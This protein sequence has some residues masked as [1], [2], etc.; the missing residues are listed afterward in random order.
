MQ[1]H[2]TYTHEQML[3]AMQMAQRL[4]LNTYSVKDVTII[5]RDDI[6][7]K[8]LLRVKDKCIAD[9]A[10]I[11]QEIKEKELREIQWK[12][13]SYLV[14]DRERMIFN[15]NNKL[16]EY[17]LRLNTERGRDENQML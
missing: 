6:S 15:F 4:A 12:A 16:M 17:N 9:L 7:Q 11:D 13:I 3:C 2:P 14:A 10:K 5:V 8:R 1:I